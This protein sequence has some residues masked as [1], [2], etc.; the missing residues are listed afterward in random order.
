MGGTA[1]STSDKA[2]QV[3]GKSGDLGGIFGR[4]GALRG[5]RGVTDGWYVTPGGWWGRTNQ[6]DLVF[7]DF[8]GAVPLFTYEKNS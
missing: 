1:A 2:S 8:K 7:D 3:R 6:K 5:A 4:F